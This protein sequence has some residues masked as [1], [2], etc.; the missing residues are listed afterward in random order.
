MQVDGNI[1]G[2]KARFIARGFS[3]NEGIDY[4]ETFAPV[5]SQVY[6]EQPLGDET[7]DRKAHVCKLKKTLY[8]LKRNPWD[9]KYGCIRSLNIT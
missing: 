9:R 6:V 4:E 3:Q 1:V 2:Y 8:E 5:T 7:Y